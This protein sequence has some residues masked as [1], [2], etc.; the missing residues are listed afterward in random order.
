MVG[1]AYPLPEQRRLARRKRLRAQEVAVRTG[2]PHE[3]GPGE[4]S[5]TDVESLPSFN[6][7]EE[8]RRW[9][10]GRWWRNVNRGMSV[11]ALMIIGGVI[12]LAIVGTIRS[13]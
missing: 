2:I 7:F 10:N 6:T 9:D 12:A 13:R 5:Q 11:V 4:D 1:A 3:W 8:S